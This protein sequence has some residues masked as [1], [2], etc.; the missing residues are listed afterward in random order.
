MPRNQRVI[1]ET[2]IKL[3]PLPEADKQ[4]TV[5]KLVNA[6]ILHEHYYPTHGI[7]CVCMD[8]LLRAFR[9]SLFGR[10]PSLREVYGDSDERTGEVTLKGFRAKDIESIH[11]VHGRIMY[12][13]QSMAKDRWY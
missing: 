2:R 11:K 6:A 5:E 3:K 9:A 13:V 7:N 1:W 4:I 10:L 8:E 12:L